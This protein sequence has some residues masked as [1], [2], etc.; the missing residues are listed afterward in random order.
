MK[1]YYLSIIILVI[2]LLSSCHKTNEA[3]TS[4]IPVK[5]K[6]NGWI[7]IDSKGETVLKPEQHIYEATFFYEGCSRVEIADETSLT[8]PRPETFINKKGEFI[9]N[10]KYKYASIFNEGIAWV[11]EENGYPTAINAKGETLF[12]LKT[13]EKAGIFTEGLAPVCFAEDGIQTWGYVNDKGK[14]VIPPAFLNCSGFF[15]NLAPAVKDEASGWGYIDKKGEFTIQPQFSEA[16]CFDN[17]GLAVVA[18]GDSNKK[19]GIIDRKGKY[20]VSPQY[21]L[22]KPDGEYYV[23]GQSDVY[24]W[25]DKKGK[26]I[27]S[28]QF[29]NITYFRKANVTGVSIDDKKWGIIDQG[30]KYTLN[31]QYDAI[32]AFIGDIAPFMMSGKAGFIDREGKIVIN[33]QYTNVASD[34]TGI[35]TMYMLN[36]DKLFVSS[37]YFDVE[38]ITS[39]LFKDSG[40]DLFRGISGN[41]TFGEIKEMYRDLSYESV[42]SRKSNETVALNSGVSISQTIFR[43]PEELSK[44]SYNYYSNTYDTQEN[45]TVTI[46]SIEYIINVDYNSKAWSKMTNIMQGVVAAIVKRYNVDENSTS[47]ISTDAGMVVHTSS[48]EFNV[49]KYGSDIHLQVSF[50]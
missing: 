35:V 19:Y 21:E 24:G 43:F 37:D 50:K 44:S 32:G 29:K 42:Y 49:Q 30:G 25:I 10:K 1:L 47:L 23:V 31:P 18:I 27:I 16:N 46:A 3:D 4:I 12:S 2:C 26:T 17:N 36:D 39:Q 6:E 20:V 8:L 41:T 7:F 34:Y 22:I 40:S 5:T 28:P 9:T 48:I 15:G 14:T 33:P 38:A 11:V 13:C 45:T